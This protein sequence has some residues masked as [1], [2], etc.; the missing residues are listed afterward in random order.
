MHDIMGEWLD[1]NDFCPS[2]RRRRSGEAILSATIGQSHYERPRGR[3]C[4]RRLSRWLCSWPT[5]RRGTADAHI[6]K[7]HLYGSDRYN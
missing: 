1:T 2:R 7:P 6:T 4:L 3:C 5:S